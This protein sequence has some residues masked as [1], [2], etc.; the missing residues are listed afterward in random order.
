MIKRLFQPRKQEQ[1]DAT[2]PGGD[3]FVLSGR[4]LASS[5]GLQRCNNGIE[6]NGVASFEVVVQ[7]GYV[8]CC[9]KTQHPTCKSGEG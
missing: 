1:D 5:D 9:C 2:R 6:L 3:D 7:R 8:F 4:D